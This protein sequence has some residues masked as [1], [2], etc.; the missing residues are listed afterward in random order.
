VT[1]CKIDQFPTDP[2]QSRGA[3]QL[4]QLA[5]DLAA[6]ITVRVRR[7]CFAHGDLDPGNK[8]TASGSDT[9][10]SAFHARF[11]IKLVTHNRLTDQK[12]WFQMWCMLSPN[13]RKDPAINIVKHAEIV[14]KFTLKPAAFIC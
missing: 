14:V 3:R 5:G 2:R 1:L 11:I 8:S 6:M 9:A 10:T 4:P 7:P 12:S 13:I